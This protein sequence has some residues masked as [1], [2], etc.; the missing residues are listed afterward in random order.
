MNPPVQNYTKL[1]KKWI[2]NVIEKNKSMTM[3][4]NESVTRS[5]FSVGD[6]E[7]NKCF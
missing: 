6:A 7:S 4:V 2:K 5:K 1:K 3:M